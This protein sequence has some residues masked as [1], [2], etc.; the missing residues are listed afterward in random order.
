MYGQLKDHHQ[1]LFHKEN[2]SSTVRS[3]SLTAT[4]A[5]NGPGG[6]EPFKTLLKSVE[7][8][9]G[10]LNS[11]YSGQPGALSGIS[12]SLILPIV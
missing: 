9:M 3:M 4:G 7:N 5:I 6:Q 2:F 8:G 1:I 11:V 10:C 12:P